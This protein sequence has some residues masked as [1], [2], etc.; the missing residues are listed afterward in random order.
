MG[1]KTFLGAIHKERL[2]LLFQYNLARATL[3]QTRHILR[4]V[5]NCVAIP[6]TLNATPRSLHMAKCVAEAINANVY[7]VMYT[8][9]LGMIASPFGPSDVNLKSDGRA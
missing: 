6:A 2:K 1:A 9:L 8:H 7:V 4:E 5:M 3:T